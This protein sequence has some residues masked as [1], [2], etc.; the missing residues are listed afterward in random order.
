MRAVRTELLAS[1][2][3]VV[4]S[5]VTLLPRRFHQHI[6]KKHKNNGLSF[7]IYKLHPL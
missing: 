2:G 6:K 1:A 4:I 7:Y 5:L 3:S